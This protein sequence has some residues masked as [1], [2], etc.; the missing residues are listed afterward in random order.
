MLY[1][2]PISILLKALTAATMS[3]IINTA[4][5]QQDP[6]YSF[7]MYNGTAI[8]PAA[9][10]SAEG[11]SAT[12]IYRKQWAGIKGAPETFNLSADAPVR[13]RKIALGF[14]VISDKI[15]VMNTTN[16]NA[17]Y[18]YRIEYRNYI[19]SLGL[20]AGLNNFNA[21]YNSVSTNPTQGVDQSFSENTSKMV[22]NFGSGLYLYNERFFAGFA[23][24]HFINNRIDDIGEGNGIQ[25]RQYRHYYLSGGYVFDLN[26]ELKLKPSA[27]IKVAEGAPIQLDVNANVWYKEFVSLGAGF[28]TNDSFTTMV[29]FQY[30]KFRFG[31]AYDIITSSLSRYTNGN[32]EIMVRY[33]LSNKKKKILTPR[34][35]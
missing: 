29:Q 5:A 17:Q 31:Y 11:F 3:L 9:A 10:G 23:I 1:Q 6:A 27:L 18:A 13:N 21:D 19:L 28:R 22:F 20:Q 30:N 12:A 24:P 15:G 33:E 7:I 32:S 16:V 25:S 26:Q 2:K 8:N 35:F 14:S 34:Y 4:V